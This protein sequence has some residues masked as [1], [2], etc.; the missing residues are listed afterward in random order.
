[1]NEDFIFPILLKEVD[2]LIKEIT[3]HAKLPLIYAEVI[4]LKTFCRVKCH[5]FV[6]CFFFILVNM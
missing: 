1:M 5:C 4:L 3:Q 2:K 6:C